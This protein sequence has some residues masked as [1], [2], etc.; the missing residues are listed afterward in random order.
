MLVGG[1]ECDQTALIGDLAAG[2]PPVAADGG[3]EALL[4]LGVMPQ[5]VIGDIDSLAPETQARLAPGGLH[6]IAEQDS[7]DFDKCLRNIRAPL[8]V[9]HGFLGA[10][11]DHQLAALTVLARHPDRRC[12]LVGR[13][14]VVLLCPPALTLPLEPGCRV[15]LWP[16]GP[17]T[18]QSTGLRWPIG[19]IGFE[20]A[21]RV[22]TSNQA[23]GPVSLTMDAPLMLVM[24]PA[25][26]RDVAQ[27]ALLGA[28][29]RW[30]A[31]AG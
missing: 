2:L 25:V 13:D 9:A 30:P 31:R 4:R 27:A 3:A 23:L 5:A 26:C 18:G 7:T 8:V 11:L 21:G 14:D 6:R 16:L 15:S 24:L 12:L 22:G 28:P 19:G 17:V 20:P 10:R 29:G 1:G